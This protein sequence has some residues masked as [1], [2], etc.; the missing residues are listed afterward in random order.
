MLDPD[1]PLNALRWIRIYPYERHWGDSLMTLPE[2]SGRFFSPERRE[3]WGLTIAMVIFSLWGILGLLLI[4]LGTLS[5]EG[6]AQWIGGILF[7]GIGAL[8]QAVRVMM[9]DH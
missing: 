4:V 8:L 7:F 2:L 6:T 9:L 5:F 1:Q 3:R